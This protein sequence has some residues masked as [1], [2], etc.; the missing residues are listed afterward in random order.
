MK[1]NIKSIIIILLFIIILLMKCGGNGG[2]K[3]TPPI[4]TIIIKHDTIKVTKDSLIKSKPKFIKGDSI[5]YAMWDTMYLP[6]TNYEKLRQQYVNN[7]RELLSKNYYVDSV[8]Y[9][10]NNYVKIWDTIQLNKLQNRSVRFNLTDLIIHDSVIITRTIKPVN[11]VYFGLGILGNKAEL[12]NGIEASLML[13]TKKDNIYE[14]KTQ[15]INNQL[16]YGIG[17]KWKIK[18]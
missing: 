3:P 11:Q 10:L 5:P 9:D 14:I 15:H 1:E 7:T 17:T 2:N 13:K 16:I 4:D 18:F 8:A 6:D 12:V